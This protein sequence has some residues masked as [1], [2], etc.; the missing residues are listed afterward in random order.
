M[1]RIVF[2]VPALVVGVYLLFI[3]GQLRLDRGELKYRKWFSWR[4][5]PADQVIPRQCFLVSGD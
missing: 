4:T 3:P 1:F 2:L 5:I